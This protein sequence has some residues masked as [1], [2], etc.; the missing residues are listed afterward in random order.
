MRTIHKFKLES[1]IKVKG[2]RQIL[3]VALQRGER[4]VWCEV[5]D[6]PWQPE[7]VV[8]FDLVGTGRIVPDKSTHLCTLQEGS[9][10]WHTYYR[11]IE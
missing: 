4:F 10:V 11:I 8:V 2:L 5:D 3:E 6:D 1:H 9:Y 7:Y